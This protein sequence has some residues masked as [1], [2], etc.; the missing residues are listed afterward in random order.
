MGAADA[1]EQPKFQKVTVRP[2][3]TLWSIANTYL[4]DPTN[5]NEILKYNRLPSSDPSVA[6]PGLVL[7]VPVYMIKE[8]LRA[9]RLIYYV[10][11]VLFRKRDTADWKGV[12]TGMDL[13][14][15]DG[16]R[17]AAEAQARVRFSGGEVLTVHQNSLAILRP[18]R[19]NTDLELLRG[20]VRGT[21]SRVL[22][23]SARITP[24]TRDT[25]F[26]ARV[27][28][29]MSTLV[30][31]YK[32]KADVEA[33]GKTVE[34]SSG[35]ATEVK[36]ELPPSSPVKMPP[37]PEFGKSTDRKLVAGTGPSI[38][39]EGSVLSLKGLS[40][41]GSGGPAGG[42]GI[43]VA[44]VGIDSDLS[45]DVRV[46]S[47]GNPI[48]GYHV[49][50][51][52]N[53]DFSLMLLNKEYSIL[54]DIDLKDAI[55]PGRYWIRISLIDLLGIEGKFTSARVLLKNEKGRISLQ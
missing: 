6:L 52:G 42:S 10:N 34:V 28:E 33:Q 24:K 4:K 29:D 5:W 9:A 43:T 11:E 48:Q 14:Q 30:Q 49:Q 44:G 55:A 26:S 20:E 47:V 37:L 50:I 32:G 8:R 40:S 46:V 54:E 18:P 36:L 1:A 23:A 45:R 41:A 15:D 27:K 25:D 17:T 12:A 31:V 22:T 3:D 53:S 21:R 7:K 51:A 38:H 2:G 13:Y 19:K 16:L 35:F 39:F